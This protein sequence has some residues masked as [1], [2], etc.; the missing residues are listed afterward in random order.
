MPKRTVVVDH[1]SL[2]ELEQRYRHAHD[3][4]ARSHFQI[5]WLLAQGKT[6]PQVA[7]VTGYGVRWIGELVRRYNQDGPEALGDR[8]HD[9]PGGQPIL[10]P[11]QQGRLRASL[12][13]A[14]PDGGLWTGPKVAAWIAAE[15]GHPAYPQL[16]WLYLVRLGARL[17]RPRPQHANA[18]PDAVAAFPKG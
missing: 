5:V 10:S 3:P 14:A 18:D 1:L 7:E 2:A 15:T 6:R 4:I 16:G 9:N 8:R 12:A 13:G 17:K 11:A